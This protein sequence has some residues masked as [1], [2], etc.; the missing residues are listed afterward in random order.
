L[1][2]EFIIV[3]K[4]GRTY[5]VT[6]V[7]SR[8]PISSE[9]LGVLDQTMDASLFCYRIYMD[10]R[11]ENLLRD[12]SDARNSKPRSKTKVG[13]KGRTLYSERAERRIYVQ[14]GTRQHNA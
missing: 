12:R 6:N 10:A 7:L 1:E 5:V 13:Q 8:L 4:H 14:I 11:S 3:Y 2:Y 9:P